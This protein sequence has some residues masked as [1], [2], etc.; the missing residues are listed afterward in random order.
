MKKLS[1]ATVRELALA[2]PDVVE[3]TSWGNPSLKAGGKLLACTPGHKS[4]EPGS[5]AIFV[6]IA[7]RAELIRQD[8]DT[9]YAPHHYQMHAVVLVRLD[10]L[11]R[12]ELKTLVEDAHRTIMAKKTQKKGQRQGLGAPG[13]DGSKVTVRSP[14]SPA[15][16]AASTR[17]STTR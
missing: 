3:S 13:S 10:T 15:M 17:P 8:P 4:A 12:A 2:L 6:P 1:F 11:T 5:V 9:F 16:K 14:N 7:R